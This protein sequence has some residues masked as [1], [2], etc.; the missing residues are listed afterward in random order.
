MKRYWNEKIDVIEGC[1][2][3]GMHKEGKF[4]LAVYETLEAA[5]GIKMPIYDLRHNLSDLLAQSMFLLNG[6]ILL[7]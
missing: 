7:L 6:F 5:C 4:P 2:L 1:L 3:I